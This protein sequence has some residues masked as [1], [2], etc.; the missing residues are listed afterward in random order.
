M[1]FET[2]FMLNREHYAECFDQS[3][4]LKGPQKPRITFIAF[5]VISGVFFLFLTEVPGLL[6]WFF[7]AIA[8]LEYVSFKYKRAWWLT[9]QMMSKNA[10]NK[11]TLIFDEKGIEN[12]SV[13]I[14]NKLA[15]QAINNIQETDMGFMLFLKN[16][17]QQYLSKQCLTEPIMT[18]L[19]QKIETKGTKA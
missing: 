4:L 18:L 14:N 9:R 1:H 15:W 8:V 3:M 13:Y 12:K 16:G 6:A 10:G 2:H 5:L 11:I 19:M 7:F 17:S